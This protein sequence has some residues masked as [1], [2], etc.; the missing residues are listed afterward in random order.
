M[1]RPKETIEEKITN[2]LD[3]IVDVI[4]YVKSRT[5]EAFRIHVIYTVKGIHNN[6][7]TKKETYWLV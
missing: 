1:K 4:P 3:N 7:H 6:T 2:S 5:K